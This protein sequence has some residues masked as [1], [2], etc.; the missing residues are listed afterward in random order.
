MD[1]IID[2]SDWLLAFVFLK[3]PAVFAAGELLLCTSQLRC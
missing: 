1:D 2:N 3:L